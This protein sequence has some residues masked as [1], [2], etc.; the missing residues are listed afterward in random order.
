MSDLRIFPAAPQGRA[1][2]SGSQYLRRCCPRRG[3]LHWRYELASLL[4]DGSVPRMG[5]APWS[6]RMSVFLSPGRPTPGQRCKCQTKA[7]GMRPLTVEPGDPPA[8]ETY[9]QEFKP[10]LTCAL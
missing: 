4:P 8:C 3:P 10:N 2:A 5:C 1:I 6:P 7:C 9:G